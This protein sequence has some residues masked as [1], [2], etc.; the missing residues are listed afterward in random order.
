MGKA[1]GAVLQVHGAA[2]KAIWL[3]D[4]MLFPLAGLLWAPLQGVGA[5]LQVRGALLQRPG[6]PLQER[7]ALA[8]LL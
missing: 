6:A 4:K 1:L 8:R 3:L 5:V 2:G 7:N